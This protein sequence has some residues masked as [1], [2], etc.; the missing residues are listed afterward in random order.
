MRRRL[1]HAGATA[2]RRVPGATVALF[3]TDRC[4]VECAHCSVGSVARGPTITDRPLFE[5]IVG[6]L[7]DLP[8]LRAVAITGGEPFAERRGL[9]YAVRRLGDAGKAVVVFTSGSWARRAVPAWVRA[10]L[11]SVGTVY[12]STDVFHAERPGMGGGTPA[13]AAEAVLAAGC[14]LVLQVLAGPDGGPPAAGF[15][16][17]A[18]EV[19]V[20]PRLP[21]GRG[22]RHFPAGPGRPSA[23]FGPCALL[24]SPTVRY[25]GVVT[26]CCN[27]SVITGSGPD[28][29]R[30]R[31][32][33]A[34][35][36]AALAAFRADPVLRLMRTAGPVGLAGVVPDTARSVC[37][38]CWA[39]ARRAAADPAA[40]RVLARR[41]AYAAGLTS[42][43]AEGGAE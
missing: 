38:P 4:P 27:E 5:G 14:H 41:A 42:G 18:A 9:E 23:D 32:T 26:A 8:G 21:A 19:S 12:L 6:G 25:D 11:A 33:G 35:V 15:T 3:L 13:R 39:A 10:V 30:R 28:A 1:T 37:G 31:V 20:V 17:P 34:G 29:L 16:H 22:A 36:G 24:D 7:A 40:R 43:A 2:L